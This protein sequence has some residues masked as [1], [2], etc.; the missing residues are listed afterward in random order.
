MAKCPWCGSEAQIKVVATD[1]IEDGWDMEVQR[2][3]VCGCGTAFVAK[4]WYHSDG[5]EEIDVELQKRG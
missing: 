2:H 4:S 3:C 1:Y 5:C